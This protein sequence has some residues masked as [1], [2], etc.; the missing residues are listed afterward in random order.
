M[1]IDSTKLLANNHAIETEICIVGAG[2]AGIAVATE[3]LTS[4]IDVV[5]LESGST[6][7]TKAGTRLAGGQRLG[8]PYAALQRTRYRAFGGSSHRWISARARPLDELDMQSRPGIP[9]S[10]WPF[11]FQTLIPFYER[12]Q[13]LLGLGPFRYDVAEWEPLA[14]AKALALPEELIRT[15]VF[16]FGPLDSILHLRDRLSAARNVRVLLNTTAIEVRTNDI[17]QH[18]QSVI[19]APEPGQHI[20]VKARH[21][22]LAGGGIENARLLLLSRGSHRHGIGNGNDLVGRFFMEH[23]HVRSGV[24]HPADGRLWAGLGLYRKQRVGAATMYATLTP[25]PLELRDEGLLASALSL[26]PTAAVLTTPAGRVLAG[27][28]TGRTQP[29]RPRP[30]AAQL[31]ALCVAPV[32]AARAARGLVARR[33]TADRRRSEVLQLH[34]MAEQA[35][36]PSSRVTLG[37]RRDRFGQPVARLDWRLGDLDL[38]SIRRGQELLDRALRRAELGRVDQLLGDERPAASVGGGCHHMGTTRMHADSKHGVVDPDCRVHDSANL[39]IAGSSVFPTSGYANPTLT[40][41]ALAARL[42]DHL[43]RVC[44]GSP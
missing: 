37:S 21:Y 12:A 24:V 5:M 41:V 2:P 19:A 4:G 1:L 6:S 40:I 35:P 32:T 3:L 29:G 13:A 44:R 31:G 27:V 7:I 34:V 33:L 26:D 8:H 15:A 11:G 9:H 30:S 18:V 38:Y 10:G 25:S 14:G 36:N 28:V 42:A 43:K 20:T 39:Y 16:Q 23:P 17:G 22:V